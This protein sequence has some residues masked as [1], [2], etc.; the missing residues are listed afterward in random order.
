M[1]IFQ[2]F[3]TDG[4]LEIVPPAHWAGYSYTPIN[5]LLIL[6]MLFVYYGC[7]AS[8]YYTCLGSQAKTKYFHLVESSVLKHTSQ[9]NF[10]KDGTISLTLWKQKSQNQL[11]C[12]QR[13]LNSS[14][15]MGISLD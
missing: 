10:D 13:L 15:V 9:A 11:E 12:T 7:I 8:A 6:I 4:K 3:S 5:W 14:T 2:C 1:K